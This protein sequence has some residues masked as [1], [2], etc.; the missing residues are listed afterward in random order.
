MASTGLYE[1]D[2]HSPAYPGALP[3]VRRLRFLGGKVK[4]TYLTKGSGASIL[5]THLVTRHED[6]A[7]HVISSCRG[8]EQTTEASAPRLYSRLLKERMSSSP[9]RSRTTWRRS[10]APSCS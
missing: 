2:R 4:D 8:C 9:A 1:V 5:L 10:S 6:P 7:L 3:E